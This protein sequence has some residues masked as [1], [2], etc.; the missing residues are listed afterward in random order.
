MTRASSS[1]CLARN[2][3]MTMANITFE[4]LDDLRRQLAEL[5]DRPLVEKRALETAGEHLRKEI[6]NSV[7][8]RSG[9]LKAA[10]TKGEVQNGKILIG[11]SQQG[12][13][14]RAHFL[15]YGTSK[16]SAKPFMRPAFEREKSRIE[17]ILAN[18]L[19]RGLGL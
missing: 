13:A 15:E 10:I 8:I 16:M 2:E 18:E 5:T 3:M 7:P 11:P 17:T 12:P 19:R 4:G 14:F 1:N 9:A 6:Q